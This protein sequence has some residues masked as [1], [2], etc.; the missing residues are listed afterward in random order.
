VALQLYWHN[1]FYWVPLL[2]VQ[3]A[4]PM[5]MLFRGLT[6]PGSF[7]PTT[8]APSNPNSHLVF[9]VPRLLLRPYAHIGRERFHSGLRRDSGPGAVVPRAKSTFLLQY[10]YVLLSGASRSACL[11]PR[12][13]DYSLAVVRV[14]SVSFHLGARY[15][16]YS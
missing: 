1:C 3:S 4:Y 14:Y 2:A 12:D 13:A 8:K 7:S 11:V 5:P 9:R 15:S 10:V 16:M 6:H